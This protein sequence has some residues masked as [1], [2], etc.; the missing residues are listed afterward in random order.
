MD[1]L[2]LL[3]VLSTV[4][5]T[6]LVGILDDLLG[7]HQAVKA[8][9]PV[10]AA[11]PL[12]AIRVGHTTLSIPLIGQVNFG[13]AYSWALV[14]LGVTGA[15]N[16]VNMLA[17]F[18]GAELG[19]GLVA[20][21]GLAAVAWKLGEPTALALL[22]AGMGA[23]LGVLFF[24]WYPARIFV[25]DVGTL[26]IGAILAASCIVGNFEAAGLIVILPYALDFVLKAMHGF[27]SKGWAGD[28]CSDKKLRCPANGPV[29]LG[30]AI[31]KVTGGLHERTLTLV[32]VGFEAL[33]AAGAALL[34]WLRG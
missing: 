34:Y 9:L 33:C 26:S 18:N 16:A 27:P 10:L 6:A 20:M 19:M 1:F 12:V 5:L 14:P 22:L 3:A 32:L 31:L 23:A 25:G 29:G 4:L 7:M 17:G 30:Q 28:L 21:G 2:A 11:L 13:L 8:F 24:N 15:A